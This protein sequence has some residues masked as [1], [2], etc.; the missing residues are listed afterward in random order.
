MLRPIPHEASRKLAQVLA[1]EASRDRLVRALG[2]C[3]R[4]G[5]EPGLGPVE[6]WD[7]VAPC[8]LVLWL[9]RFEGHPSEPLAPDRPGPIAVYA[10][11][12]DPEHVR[13]HVE[14]ILAATSPAGADRPPRFALLRQDDNG[15]RVEMRRFSSKCAAEHERDVFEARGHKQ[16]YWVEP[17]G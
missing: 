3:A 15:N 9:L 4:A 6:A 16:F 2:P 1:G 14:P 17:L 8:G 11:D 10:S 12:D 5:E 13:G 7:L